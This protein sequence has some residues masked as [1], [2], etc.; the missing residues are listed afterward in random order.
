MRITAT[1]APTS[2]TDCPNSS[3]KSSP[4]VMLISYPARCP[5]TPSGVMPR[6]PLTSQA[7]PAWQVPHHAGATA[8]TAEELCTSLDAFTGERCLHRVVGREDL[9]RAVGQIR[10]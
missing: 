2:V 1:S 4:G 9:D 8:A 6:R 5:R 3:F 7:G 10:S